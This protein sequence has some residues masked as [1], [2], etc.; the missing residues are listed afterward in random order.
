[1]SCYALG[2][3]T[4]GMFAYYF[5]DVL[6]CSRKTL[7]QR[8]WM[9]PSDMS[10]AQITSHVLPMR[11]KAVAGSLDPMVKQTYKTYDVIG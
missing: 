10:R 2:R 5:V 6:K 4:R 11:L 8:Y 9:T 1:M 3:Y 7:H